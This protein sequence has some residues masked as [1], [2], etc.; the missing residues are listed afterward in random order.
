MPPARQ[1]EWHARDHRLRVVEDPE[2]PVVVVLQRPGAIARVDLAALGV[3]V[4]VV[5]GAERPARAAQDDDADASSSAAASSARRERVHQR[6]VQRVQ[7]ARPVHREPA[8]GPEVV[9]QQ[10]GFGD[11]G[12][13]HGVSLH[14]RGSPGARTWAPGGR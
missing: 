6:S 9:G 14:D 1:Y 7:R 3:L 5:A 12:V 13:A 11:R 8:D 10:D 2:H 4:Q